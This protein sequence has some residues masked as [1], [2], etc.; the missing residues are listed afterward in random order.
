[1]YTKQKFWANM[2]QLSDESCW[3][4]QGSTDEHGYGR[5]H[6]IDRY[7]HRLMHTSRVAWELS[8]NDMIPDNFCVLHSCDTPRCCNPK[9]LFLG[10]HKQNAI[11]AKLK[12]RLETKQQIYRPQVKTKKTHKSKARKRSMQNLRKFVIDKITVHA[13]VA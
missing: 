4:W 5:V 3:L 12:K 9:H 2:T 11:D 6:W 1:M 8:N 7:G 13:T 10:T